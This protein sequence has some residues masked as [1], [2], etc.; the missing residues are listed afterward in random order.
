MKIVQAGIASLLVVAFAAALP[1]LYYR[2]ESTPDRT[3]GNASSDVRDVDFTTV[4]DL[5]K[6]EPDVE[7][8]PETT[9][10]VE[11]LRG[12][13]KK[14]ARR[15][16]M[17]DINEAGTSRLK[18]ITGIGDK[19]AENIVNYRE[20][21]GAI[22]SVSELD[23]VSGIGPATSKK[24]GRQILID[25]RMPDV[26]PATSGS[27]NASGST[28]SIN[29]NTADESDLSKLSGIGPVTAREIIKYR[30][31]QGSIEDIGELTNVK[32]IGPATVEK[33]R[34]NTTL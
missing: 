17:V 23:N 33:L 24:I 2:T 32:G 3:S 5:S 16:L 26:A 8:L 19:T 7:E 31:E 4:S 28:L 1:G 10:S 9:V 21:N 29:V 27:G 20:R 34:K 22:S 25:G 11:K 18:T 14:R 13:K 6:P 30:N 15:R 12:E